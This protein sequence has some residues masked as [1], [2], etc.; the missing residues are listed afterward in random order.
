LKTSQVKNQNGNHSK[1]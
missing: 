1:L